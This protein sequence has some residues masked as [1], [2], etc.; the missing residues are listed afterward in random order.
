M[1][2]LNS[3]QTNNRPQQKSICELFKCNNFNTLYWSWTYRGCRHQPCLLI[4]AKSK[5]CQTHS[6]KKTNFGPFMNNSKLQFAPNSNSRQIQILLDS[7]SC[8]IQ[9]RTRFKFVPDSNSRTIQIR[10]QLK[11]AHNS[12]SHTIQIRTQFKFAPKSTNIPAVTSIVPANL[13]TG[14][15][16]MSDS[17]VRVSRQFE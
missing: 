6:H 15:A 11:F 13:T 17:L 14:L 1:P 16:H 12:N 2:N 4:C 5:S 9:N 10:T 7:N 3:H 8:R